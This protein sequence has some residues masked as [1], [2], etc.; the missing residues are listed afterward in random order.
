M[1]PL[2]T[3]K[4]L[5]SKGNYGKKKKTAYGITENTCKWCDQQGPNFQNTQ[6]AHKVNNQKTKNPI[7]KPAEDL[8]RQSYK[9]NTQMA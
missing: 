3:Y 2:Q 9:E 1:G 8:S 7:K 5:H 4:L 6:T